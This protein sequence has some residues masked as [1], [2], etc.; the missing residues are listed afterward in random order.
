MKNIIQKDF[1]ES[2]CKWYEE[3]FG[4]ELCLNIGNILEKNYNVHSE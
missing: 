2:C 3:T 1:V 4:V